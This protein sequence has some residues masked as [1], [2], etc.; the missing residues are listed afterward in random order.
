MDLV[1]QPIES[2]GK[3]ENTLDGE[4]LFHMISGESLSNL[5]LPL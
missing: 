2:T 4:E 1:A 3:Q 5:D